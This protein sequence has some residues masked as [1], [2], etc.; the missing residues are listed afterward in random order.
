[1]GKK[2]TAGQRTSTPLKINGVHVYVTILHIA[3]R[4]RE[5]KIEKETHDNKWP[6]INVSVT[7]LQNRGGG[8]RTDNKKAISVKI[9]YMWTLYML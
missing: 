8:A 9:H 1:M 4:R 2:S 7:A 6:N 5:G 3:E